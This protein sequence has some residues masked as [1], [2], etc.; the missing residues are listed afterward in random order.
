M[1]VRFSWANPRLPAADCAVTAAMLEMHDSGG[2]DV[3]S[4]AASPVVFVPEKQTAT[5]ARC[6]LVALGLP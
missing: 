5:E 1:H 3:A 2:Q 4:I 6:Q